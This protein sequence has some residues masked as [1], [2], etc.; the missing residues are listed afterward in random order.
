RVPPLAYLGQRSL[1]LGEGL[2]RL[3]R[4]R[5]PAVGFDDAANLLEWQVGEERLAEGG[6]V[7][8]RPAAER[9]VHPRDGRANGVGDV[10]DV[11]L[12]KHRHVRVQAG[13]VGEVVE[14]GEP[15]NAHVELI[16][17]DPG[18]L[19]QWQADPAGSG[20]L[21]PYQIALGLE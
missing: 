14:V 18:E 6:A 13:G 5:P 4:I 3:G 21:V 9:G 10:E 16:E 2:D 8:D 12:V 11:S 19:D 17:R 1:E 15:V 7:S 20:R